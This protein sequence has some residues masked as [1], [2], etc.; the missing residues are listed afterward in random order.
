LLKLDI[1]RP[2]HPA[3]LLGFVGDELAEFG[4]QARKHGA[5]QVGKPRLD[6]RIGE[7]RVDLLVESVDNLDGRVLGRA[8]A[9][10]KKSMRLLP[11][12]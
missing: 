5:A 11:I 7:S 8:D 3:P 6:F 12:P 2:D 9:I 1:R 4:R 10:A